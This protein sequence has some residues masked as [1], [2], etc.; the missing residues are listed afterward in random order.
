LTSTDINGK[1]TFLI[2]K[3][4]VLEAVRELMVDP[5]NGRLNALRERHRLYT[6]RLMPS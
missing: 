6:L 1:W 2:S 4:N 3:D 5:E